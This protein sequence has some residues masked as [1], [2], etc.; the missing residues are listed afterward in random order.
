MNLSSVFQQEERETIE[1]W[2]RSHATSAYLGDHRALCRVLG[3]LWM[4][5]DTRDLSVTPH[6]I[7]NGFWESW[8]TQAVVRYVK[9]GMRCL[10]IGANC[11][12]YTLLLASLVGPHGLVTAYEPYEPLARLLTQSV[13]VNG[14]GARVTVEDSAVG[15]YSG[16]ALLHSRFD[17]LGSSTL[18]VLAGSSEHGPVTQVRLDDVE[19]LSQAPIDFVKIDVQGSEILVLDGM[20]QIIER[21]PKIA[22][23]MEFA[24]SDFENPLGALEKIRSFGFT[25]RTIGTD[26]TVR[27]ISAEQCIEPDT[28]EHR[29][30][31]LSKGT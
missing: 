27:H 15:D 24:P 16:S 13:T 20:R 1:K 31:W 10:D 12:Y 3:E 21:S 4:Y 22:I 8:V 7:M 18:G 26:G 19:A 14:F 6:M 30:L 11:G 23:A 28:G 2:C 9:P 29:M 17:L 5:V 25:I